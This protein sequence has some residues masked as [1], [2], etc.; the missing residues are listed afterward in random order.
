MTVQSCS[1]LKLVTE[2]HTVSRQVTEGSGERE[3]WRKLVVKSCVVPQ[4]PWRLKDR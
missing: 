3:K 4:R 1:P 2:G